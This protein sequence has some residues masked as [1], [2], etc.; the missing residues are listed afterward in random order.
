MN[1][2]L[3]FL[4]DNPL[5]LL[6]IAGWVFGAVANAAKAAK[7]R[8]G[9]GGASPS[10]RQEPRSAPTAGP[11][12]E[13][14]VAREIR[15]A[16]GLD[17]P[18]A[19]PAQ[20]AEPRAEPRPVA[21]PIVRPEPVRLPPTP[22]SQPVR[23]QPVRPQPSA[24]RGGE[25][26]PTP[27]VPTT[28]RRKIEVHVDP[29]VGQE[30]QRRSAVRPSTA[31]DRGLGELGGRVEHRSDARRLAGSRYRPQDLRQAIVLTEV[32]GPPLAMRDEPRGR[33]A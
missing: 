33:R 11:R 4:L 3:R 14:D 17:P 2:L 6:L 15:R 5:L 29:H 27:V 13:D 26:P 10:P 30:M 7:R 1:P 21:P 22:R 28:N 18:A 31:Q 9:G 25:R 12:T 20:R 8:Q 32:L 19:P 24:A 23:P 16:L